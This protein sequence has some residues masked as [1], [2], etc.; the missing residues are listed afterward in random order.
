MNKRLLFSAVLAAMIGAN[1]AQA[2][3]PMAI[4]AQVFAQT[5]SGGV[6]IASGEDVTDTYLKN[7]DF[8]GS[9]SIASQPNSDRAIY[10]PTGWT[11]TRIGSDKND[12]TVLKSGD[13]AYGSFSAFDSFNNPGNYN[14]GT[15]T[16][17]TRLRWSTNTGLKL[18]Q[19][20]T[21]PQGWYRI[22][23]D[24]LHYDSS[25]K[26][27]LRLLAGSIVAQAP[28]SSAKDQWSTLSV[29]FYSD[30]ESST[31]PVGFLMNHIEQTEMITAFD[32]VKLEK[33]DQSFSS[34]TEDT[35]SSNMFLRG[36]FNYVS[37]DGWSQ[38]F[39]QGSEQVNFQITKNQQGFTGNFLEMWKH[40]D[41]V[42]A[43]KMY[44]TVKNLPAGIYKLRMEAFGSQ[45]A[46]GKENLYIYAGDE[47]TYVTS[48]TKNTYETT[49]KFKGGDMEIG[50]AQDVAS[51][52]WIGIN[53]VELLYC[54]TLPNDEAY[55][56]LQ[57]SVTSAKTYVGK[58]MNSDI[59]A[60]LDAAISGAEGLTANSEI[61]DINSAKTTLDALISQVAASVDQ[62]TALN[63]LLTSAQA[64]AQTLDEAGKKVFDEQI[65]TITDSYTNA[66]YA[67]DYTAAQTSVREALAA[68][69]KAQTTEGAD[70]T[71][72]LAD[73]SFENNGEGWQG[74]ETVN[75]TT[76]N[77]EAYHKKFDM[78]QEVSGLPTGT[79][80]LSAQT[81]QRVGE[82]TSENLT[83]YQEGKE[84]VTAWLY[85]NDVKVQ[86]QSAYSQTMESGGAEVDGNHYVNGMSDFQEVTK[87]ETKFVTTLKVAVI[88]GKLKIGIKDDQK[89][90][91]SIWDN[92]KLR[93]I[94]ADTNALLAEELVAAAAEAQ[95]YLDGVEA[96]QGVKDALANAI[97]QGKAV[98]D[99]P[100]H[101]ADQ[102]SAAKTAIEEAKDQ[103]EANVK[104][105]SDLATTITNAHVPTVNIGDAA[106]QISQATVDKFNAEIATAQEMKADDTT[107]DLKAA[108]I[109]LN[110]AILTYSY[111]DVALNQPK[112]GEKFNI[113]INGNDGYQFN[114][115]TL[116]FKSGYVGN[117]EYAM[118]YTEQGGS[119]YKQTV[120]MVPIDGTT[121]GYLL[122][123]DE[124]D[125]TQTYVGTGKNYGGTDQQLRATPDKEKALT[126]KIEATAKDGLYNL[127]NT[128]NGNLIGG[129]GSDNTGFF[130]PDPKYNF[131]WNNF[132]LVS[133]VKNTATL[134]VTDAKWATFIA[135]FDV[136]IPEGVSAYT[137][138]AADGTSLT[139]KE[140]T[141][142]LKAN[143][144]YILYA[145]TPV[146]QKVEGYALA[147]TDAYNEG[148]LTGVYTTRNLPKD[149]RNYVLQNQDGRVAFYLATT[150]NVR[151]IANRAYLTVPAEVSDA[152][153]F[154][155]GGDVTAIS[156]LTGNTG[157]VE[158]ER[159]NAAGAKVTAPVKGLNLV[160]MSD[161]SIIKVIVK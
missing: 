12:M 135:P 108:T 64:S 119:F 78:Y 123:I 21:L 39:K 61:D 148:W 76:Q 103:V 62:Y 15:K 14:H 152:K 37:N 137:C 2:Y 116:T 30:G 97:T 80:E 115:K 81:M 49:T 74:K 52:N 36:D 155:F 56:A 77:A 16:Y 83:K 98:A 121:N 48:A 107:D 25:K 82:Y 58:K 93:Y 73:P 9:Y 161:G 87:D 35:P 45:E 17:W 72:A 151:C 132:N 33:L 31:I 60:Q 95:I 127:R 67:G 57:E 65:K 144:P 150:D 10:A 149:A 11:P 138:A 147:K 7:A 42:C 53:N 51:S 153:M 159:Y 125:G 94:T 75:S 69:A 44:T 40:A 63:S 130:T 24:V 122:A 154:T 41:N 43:G 143:T 66:T 85:A 1:E 59:A 101:T 106:F 88:D 26:N 160:K 70:M 92:F 68:G 145:E 50:I 114:G 99:D 120:T 129:N 38:T 134:K 118:G 109:K 29:E 4:P 157:A 8:E 20:I 22:S 28:V 34:F 86:A 19:N 113:V 131:S 128:A 79:Y 96:N 136:V 139:L 32:N 54:G 71:L 47:K 133:A 140:T 3:H 117:G 6:K 5:E 18:M 112:E 27:G 100:Q 102:I 89:V 105:Y 104:A 111:K 142:T 46:E 110:K 156:K 158:V 141:G 90:N 55:A 91:W 126:V 84:V 124:T 146:E 23:A 13:K